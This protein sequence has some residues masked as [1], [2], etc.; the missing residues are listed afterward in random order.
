L[1]VTLDLVMKKNTKCGKEK[2]EKSANPFLST[3]AAIRGWAFLELVGEDNL[4]F[5]FAVFPT[6]ATDSL[7][8]VCKIFFFVRVWLFLFVCCCFLMFHHSQHLKKEGRETNLRRRGWGG[9]WL[10]GKCSGGG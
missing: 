1:S 2:A 4:T 10:D 8:R 5:C 6:S 9:R 7:T 3:L